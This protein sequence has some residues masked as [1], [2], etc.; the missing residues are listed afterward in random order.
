MVAAGEVAVIQRG[1]IVVVSGDPAG[2]Q[3][4]S[5]R[6]SGRASGRG[7][8]AV[9]A[10]G[11]VAVICRGGVAEVAAGEALRGSSRRV[12]GVEP[13]RGPSGHPA[14]S[15]GPRRR[16]SAGRG[17]GVSQRSDSGAL[18]FRSAGSALGEAAVIYRGGPSG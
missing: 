3:Q 17:S 15:S 14:G 8:V 12:D 2:I 9:V 16:P 11:E 5:G 4:A 6:P 7:G 18:R 1:V 13:L 10:T